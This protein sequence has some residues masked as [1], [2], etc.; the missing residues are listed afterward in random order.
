MCILVI[1]KK[2]FL[3]PRATFLEHGQHLTF[4]SLGC[5][6]LNSHLKRKVG[7]QLYVALVKCSS[8]SN[9]IDLTKTSS[10]K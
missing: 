9:Q 5:F 6:D 8:I 2:F 4:C 3:S 1:V 7:E 10:S